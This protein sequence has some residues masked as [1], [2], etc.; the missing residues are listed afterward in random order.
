MAIVG[1]R[2]GACNAEPLH[3]RPLVS[4][5]VT[6][7]TVSQF[8]AEQPFDLAV[9]GVPHGADL[10]ESLTLKSLAALIGGQGYPCH[11]TVRCCGAM[12]T[13][14]RRDASDLLWRVMKQYA[15]VVISLAMV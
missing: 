11:K 12:Q 4:A 7:E 3:R 8:W 10:I 1:I 2:A 6:K 13:N 9:N 5:G 14:L 15:S